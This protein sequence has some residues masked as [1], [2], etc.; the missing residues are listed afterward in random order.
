MHRWLPING[1]Q[2]AMVSQS[3]WSRLITLAS[4]TSTR[5]WQLQL[6]Q[7]RN[8]TTTPVESTPTPTPTPTRPERKGRGTVGGEEGWRSAIVAEDHH[9][10]D[11]YQMSETMINDNDINNHNTSS[12]SIFVDSN[13]ATPID[14]GTVT[15]N[16]GSVRYGSVTGDRYQ[17]ILLDGQLPFINEDWMS[18]AERSLIEQ[19]DSK[20][21]RLVRPRISLSPSFASMHCHICHHCLC[22]HVCMRQ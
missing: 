2:T 1:Q 6:Q 17:R 9:F 7:V 20:A 11:D 22:H 12:S 19:S 15:A 10:N 8:L 18:T 13:N 21:P 3:W 5:R 16:D 4:I 14:S